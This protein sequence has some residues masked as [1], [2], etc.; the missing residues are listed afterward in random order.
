MKHDD[1][2]T[3]TITIDAEIKTPLD[4]VTTDQ[5]AELLIDNNIVPTSR[6]FDLINDD[7]AHETGVL[8]NT[9][10]VSIK[11]QKEKP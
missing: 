6:I 8:F 2:I 1:K 4:N 7:D 11:P 10:A 9:F 5:L 3:I